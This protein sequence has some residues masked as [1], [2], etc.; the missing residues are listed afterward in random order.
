MIAHASQTAPH[1]ANAGPGVRVDALFWLILLGL[2]ITFVLSIALVRWQIATIPVRTITLAATFAVIAFAR[3][4]TIQAALTEHPQ[5]LWI[6]A[7]VGAIGAAV[8]LAN[9][10]APSLMFR[11]ILEIHVQA[12]LTLVVAAAALH[13]LGRQAFAAILICVIA[14]SAAVAI[15]QFADLPGSWE[16]RAALGDI[17]KDE[18]L[19]QLIYIRQERALGLSMSPVH[20]GTQLCLALCAYWAAFVLPHDLNPRF[21]STTRAFAAIG[22]AL[23]VCVA[24]GN[25]SPLLGI[26]ALLALF[27][28]TRNG[29]GMLLIAA[30]AL[31]VVP[32]M[33]VAISLLES[34]GLRVGSTDDGSALG[35][36]VLQNYGLQLFLVQPLGYGLGFESGAHWSAYWEEFQYLEN[37]NAIR[38]HA[39]HNYFL[40]MLCKYG[41]AIVFIGLWVTAAIARRWELLLPFVAYLVHIF[42]HNDGPLQADFLFWFVAPLFSWRTRDAR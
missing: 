41:V 11:Q 13:T 28:A 23:L 3:P 21:A 31:I 14:A 40:N 20:L 35:R 16:V 24:T 6:I 29:A 10:E 2:F 36:V 33:P 8:S 22:A 18:R 5:K 42:F 25:R 32:L 34:F 39:L 27:L 1:E 12:A 19:T 15:G 30:T 26:L 37:V 38:Q 17:Q 7:I 4:K 9:G